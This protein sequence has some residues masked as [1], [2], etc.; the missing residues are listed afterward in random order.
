MVIF[1]VTVPCLSAGLAIIGV[2]VGHIH[3]SQKGAT[4]SGK[5]GS[6]SLGFGSFWPYF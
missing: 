2:E 4:P 1:Y 3:I 6:T 5:F